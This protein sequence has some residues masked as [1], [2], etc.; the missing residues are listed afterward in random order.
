MVGYAGYGT[1]EAADKRRAIADAMMARGAGSAPQ[2]VGEGLSAV[3]QALFGMLAARANDKQRAAGE[4]DAT[5]QYQGVIGALSRPQSAPVPAKPAMGGASVA[6]NVRA[7]Y[8]ALTGKG[9][10]PHIAAALVGNMMQESGPELDTQAVGDGGNSFGAV[11]WNGKRKDAF[12]EWARNNRR[13]PADIATQVDYLDYEM[14][15]PEASAAQA[16]ISAPDAESAAVTASEKFWRPGDPRNEN[17]ARYAREIAAAMGGQQQPIQSAQGGLSPDLLSLA[18]NDWLN[19][20]QQAV[21][22]AL[23][24]NELRAMQPMTP[25]ERLQAEKLGLEIENLRAP[26]MTPYQQ[27]QLDLER[28]RLDL[29]GK[30]MGRGEFGLSPVWGTDADGNPSLIQLGRDGKPIQPEMPDG[31]QIARDPIRI[32]AGTQTILL[33]PQTRQVIGAIPN[34]V[35]GAA[36]AGAVGR[37]EGERIGAAPSALVN[38]DIMLSSIDAVLNDE[39]LGSVTGWGSYIPFDIPGFNAETRSR[40]EQI[41]GQTFLSAYNQ[42]R[43]GGQITEVEGKKAE[44]AQARL[45]TAQ[46]E[47]EFRNALIELREIVLAARNRAAQ[48]IPGG[49]PETP[50]QQAQQPKAPAAAPRVLRYNPETGELE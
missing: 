24:S 30:N 29:Q 37:A 43:G 23:L 46:T 8:G 50:Q 32:D 2:N 19:P 49:L 22:R 6:P 4:N 18:S 39:K 40:I 11:Q 45:K 26:R 10:A 13:D 9:Y 35:A 1:R 17:R 7:A 48:R 36:Q 27:A 20:Q 12:F 15:G 14:K 16:I 21:V 5:A 31:F 47:A 42:L 38:A 44:Q 41:Q 34:D 25:A 28:Q 33:D 3:G